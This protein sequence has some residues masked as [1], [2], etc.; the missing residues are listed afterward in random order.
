M[1]ISQTI[2]LILACIA[3]IFGIRW[4]NKN[5]NTWMIAIPELSWLIH[6]IIFYLSIMF[7]WWPNGQYSWWSSGLRL[8]AVITIFLLVLYRNIGEGWRNGK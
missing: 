4:M 7:K 1:N 3:F 5:N 8:H 2:S 6:L